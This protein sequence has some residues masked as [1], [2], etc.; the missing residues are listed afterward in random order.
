MKV[1][2][3]LSFVLLLLTG[4]AQLGLPTPQ[5]FDQRLAVAYGTH[6][7][8]METATAALIAK[9]ITVD[10]AKQVLK[11]ADE[12]RVL[13]DA[14]RVVGDPTVATNKLVLATQILTGLQSFLRERK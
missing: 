7:A 8:V 14:A 11:L 9:Q 10:D 6:T 1:F 2:A 12:S 4:C 3:R 5:T 13:L